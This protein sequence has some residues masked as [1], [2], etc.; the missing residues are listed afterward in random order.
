MFEASLETRRAVGARGVSEPNTHQREP[1]PPG[2]AACEETFTRAM[3]EALWVFLDLLPVCVSG[4]A[5]PLDPPVAVGRS[6]HSRTPVRVRTGA[7]HRAVQGWG[8]ESHLLNKGL[9]AGGEEHAWEWPCGPASGRVSACR[10]GA[11]GVPELLDRPRPPG[12]GVA[13]ASVP[14][15]T[16]P[17]SFREQTDILLP[18]SLARENPRTR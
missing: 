16:A 13:L 7:G 18:P 10:A 17:T 14:P 6:P 9:S 11:A 4:G 8:P 15:R 12:L 5:D 2:A 3:E 1:H